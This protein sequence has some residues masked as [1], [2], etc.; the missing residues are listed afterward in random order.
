MYDQ[1]MLKE[2]LEENKAAREKLDREIHA[3][4]AEKDAMDAQI[5][6]LSEQFTRIR[7]WADEFDSATVVRKKMILARLIEKITVDRNYHLTV[8]F[9]VTQEDFLQ[10]AH[11]EDV[12]VRQT[13][14]TLQ[15]L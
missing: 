2:M 4:R 10:A 8:F 12:D 11:T 14:E 3:C 13:Q 9:F 6:H 5:Q 1:K 15:V 7:Q